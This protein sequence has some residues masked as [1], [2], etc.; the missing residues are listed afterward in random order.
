MQWLV[1]YRDR[2]LFPL[3]IKVH[4]KRLTGWLKLFLDFLEMTNKISAFIIFPKEETLGYWFNLERNNITVGFNQYDEYNF[5][6][7]WFSFGY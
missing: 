2:V 5:H 3:F 1:V 4:R 6:V 7:L